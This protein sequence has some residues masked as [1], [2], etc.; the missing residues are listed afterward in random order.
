MLF[1]E[2]R[3]VIQLYATRREVVQRGDTLSVHIGNLGQIKLQSL[4][5]GQKPFTDSAEFLD[6]RTD[7]AAFES[8]SDGMIRSS[9]LGN[10]Q[11]N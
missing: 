4:V 1:H 10:L 8:E 9:G 2:G 5:L 11:H 7:D 3:T 6:P